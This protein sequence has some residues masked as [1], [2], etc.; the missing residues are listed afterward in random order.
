MNGATIWRFCLR[1]LSV[2]LYAL[3]GAWSVVSGAHHLARRASGA[4]KLLGEAITCP[5]C[6]MR[7]ALHGRWKCRACG[8]TYR[9]FV[10]ECPLCASGA[11]FFDCVCGLSIPLTR[12]LP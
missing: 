4:T 8:A 11:S 10:L 5:G 12:H 7:N 6:E 1:V 2:P 9:G 3:Y